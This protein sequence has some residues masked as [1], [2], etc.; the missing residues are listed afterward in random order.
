MF[1]QFH[2][3]LIIGDGFGRLVGITQRKLL[4]QG[5]YYDNL[6]ANNIFYAPLAGCSDLPFRKMSCE[7]R[8]GL[9]YCEMGMPGFDI[10]IEVMDIAQG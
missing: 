1:L 10:M 8:P 7:Y 6:L 9:I 3:R 2:W 5:D 4:F